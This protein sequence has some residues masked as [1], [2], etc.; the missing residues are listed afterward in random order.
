MRPTVRLPVQIRFVIEA[1]LHATGTATRKHVDGI[2]LR[3]RSV[4]GAV[5]F[6]LTML[7]PTLRLTLEAGGHGVG[8]RQ[9][10]VR[11]VEILDRRRRLAC[12]R[13]DRDLGHRIR[14]HRAGIALVV[15]VAAPNAGLSVAPLTD[16][17]LS[18]ASV[19]SATV[20]A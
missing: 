1:A 13:G 4:S 5:T 7:L 14:D 18:V 6:T 17:A 3:G 15:V 8:V 2:G 12:R 20:F 19:V 10:G 9:C 16:R 11:I